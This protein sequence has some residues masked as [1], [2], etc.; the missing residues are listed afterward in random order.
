[1]AKPSKFYR[2]LVPLTLYPA[3][4]PVDRA[5]VRLTG[6]SL[7]N[8]IYAK[9]GG[10]RERPCLLMTTTHWKTGVSKTVVLPY[11][12]FGDQ[13]V[14]QGSLAGRPKDPVWATNIR[15]HPLTWLK[16]QGKW[17][18]C[19]AH[20]AQGEER[21]RLWK[22]ISADGAYVGYAKKAYPRIIPLVVHTPIDPDR[23]EKPDIDRAPD[24][25]T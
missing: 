6:F 19:R 25:A 14:V 1:M 24:A 11:H 8:R 12:Q 13:Y 15:A 23:A 5:L 10:V 9:A 21:E 20:V 3:S 18:F 22:S 16:V 4:L 17:L 2:R 7:T